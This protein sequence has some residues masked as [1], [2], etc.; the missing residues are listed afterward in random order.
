MGWGTEYPEIPIQTI[1]IVS[2][3][4]KQSKAVYEFE[5]LKVTEFHYEE[6]VFWIIAGAVLELW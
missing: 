5:N 3:Y 2:Y 6:I 4:S 1:I